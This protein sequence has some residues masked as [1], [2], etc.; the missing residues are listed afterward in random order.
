M[1]IKSPLKTPLTISSESE[2]IDFGKSLAS[3]LAPPAIIELIGDVG[4]GKTTFTRGLA[5][6]LGVE[7]AITSPSFT[8]SKTYAFPGGV[9]T[10]YDFY[11]LADPG[12]MQDDLQESIYEPH[13]ITVVEWADSVTDIL[14][15]KRLRLQITLNDD[16]SRTVRELA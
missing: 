2:M 3:T 12:L 4:A 11:R 10:H 9:L 13:T 5:T 7:E 6:G 16:G 14:P 1:R 8:I 15:A